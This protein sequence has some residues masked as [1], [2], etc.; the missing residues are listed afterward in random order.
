MKKFSQYLAFVIG[1]LT[2]IAFCFKTNNDI[3]EKVI[4][5]LAIYN[6]YRP[7]EKIYIHVDK[8]FYAAGENLW[9]KTY[10]IDANSNKLDS[11]S[12]VIYIELLSSDKQLLSQKILYSPNG[13]S[14]GDF[15]LGD[16]LVQGKYLLRAYT[17]YMKN[18]GDNFFFTKEINILNPIADT[19]IDNM[20]HAPLVDVQFFAEGGNFVAGLPN[21]V[22][23]KSTGPDGRGLMLEGE[24]TDD[25]NTIITTFKTQHDGMGMVM[26]TPGTD[27]KYFARIT[28]TGFTSNRYELPHVL[29][30]GFVMQATDVGKSIKVTIY[31]SLDKPSSG[32]AVVNIVAQSRGDVFFAASGELAG[33]AFYAYIPKKKLPTGVSQITLFDGNGDP[34]CERLVFVNRLQKSNLN[35]TIPKSSFAK[36]ERVQLDLTFTNTNGESTSGNFSIS[37]YDNTKIKSD[38][39]FPLTIENYLL[40][41]SEL[42]GLIEEPGY[43]FKD[44]LAETKSHA[45]LLMMTHG[46]RRYSW[47][48]M[49]TDTLPDLKFINE[50][51]IAI[52]GKLRKALSNKPAVGSTVKILSTKGDFI[53]VQTDSAGR[54]YTD[55]LLY[56]DSSEFVIQTDNAKGKQ[57]ELKF[58]L[59]PFNPFYVSEYSLT[60]FQPWDAQAFITQA[61]NR[62]RI[63]KSYN[64]GKDTTL[65]TAVEVKA[66]RIKKSDESSSAKLYG[67]PSATI[68]MADIVG[69]ANVLQA[70]QGRVAGVSVSGSAPNMLVTIRG[71]PA[72]FL[73]N[74]MK[75]DI[76]FILSIAPSDVESVDIV[77]GSG[78]AIYGTTGLIAINLKKNA[79]SRPLVGMHQRKYPGFYKGKEF[80][81]PK[82]DI[83]NDRHKMED[84]RNTLY[85]NPTVNTDNKGKAHLTFYTSD[86]PSEY[87]IVVEGLTNDGI[88]IYH[89]S[90]FEIK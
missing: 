47:K 85:W 1:I 17:N 73:L 40:L 61:T 8:P 56:N 53:A 57:T 2:L 23:F 9:F 84:V 10:L 14:H 58:Q 52:S 76:D 70:I 72:V 4:A 79:G 49:L 65:L 29:N 37:V 82:Y 5:K 32:H 28:T 11:L 7:L 20:D 64:F 48:Q 19:G 21:R 36:R 24:I 33:V 15:H 12:R 75:V 90:T 44:T 16:T 83:P 3:L 87:K 26:I 59:D 46:W 54:F 13:A 34:Q 39:R 88:P 18:V 41:T 89:T 60:S 42:K 86:V 74:G 35:L 62:A 6:Q 63:E 77:K 43:Y 67:A 27:K 50:Q 25:A 51:G 80:Y 68:K 31:G 55:D 66:S 81:S 78:A 22:G 45:N 69:S 38:E 30:K 71:N